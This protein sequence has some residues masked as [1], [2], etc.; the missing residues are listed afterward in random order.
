MK[1]LQERRALIIPVH[2][3]QFSDRRAYFLFS[4]FQLEDIIKECSVQPVPFSQNYLE[5]IASW[6]DYVVPVMSLEKRIGLNYSKKMMLNRLI[7]LRNISGSDEKRAMIRTLPAI[8][9][10]TLPIESEPVSFHDLIP[11][12]SL[13]RGMYEWAEGYLIVVD[14]EKILS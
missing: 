10:L 8:R 12:P 11:E 1:N 4:T 7:L 6:R 9:M 14:V 2:T 13:V 5:G 3:D